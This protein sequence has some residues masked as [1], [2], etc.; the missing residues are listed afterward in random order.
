MHALALFLA[1]QPNAVE[2]YGADILQSR[3]VLTQ[4]ETLTS[5]LIVGRGR[6]PNDDPLIY[7]SGLVSLKFL[8]ANGAIIPPNAGE[9]RPLWTSPRRFARSILE[10]LEEAWIC[11]EEIHV[12]R[13]SRRND[14]GATDLV[15]AYKN[16]SFEIAGGEFMIEI[17]GLRVGREEVGED[18]ETLVGGVHGKVRVGPVKVL[19]LFEPA[20]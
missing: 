3:V 16:R 12:L 7:D 14:G 18:C 4:G 5:V 17:E 13:R 1:V 15:V 8:D 10:P 2:H 19:S 11:L 9:F 6:N 20:D